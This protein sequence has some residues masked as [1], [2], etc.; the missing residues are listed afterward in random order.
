MITLAWPVALR[1]TVNCF[2]RRHGHTSFKNVFKI[3]RL[4]ASSMSFTTQHRP[5][6]CLFISP[7]VSVPHNFKLVC[8][9]A[10][11]VR[12]E[13]AYQTHGMLVRH[14]IDDTSPLLNRSPELLKREDAILSLSVVSFGVWDLS[15]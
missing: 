5:P 14:V 13:I 6:G 12:P 3:F 9:G 7:S 2:R 15:R 1:L 4:D 8:R 11:Q 10:L